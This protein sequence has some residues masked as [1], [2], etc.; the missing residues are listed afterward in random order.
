MDYL[1]TLI[2]SGGQNTDHPFRSVLGTAGD[3]P[4][5]ELVTK[6]EM[7][8]KQL[9][10]WNLEK[11]EM[12]LECFSYVLYMQRERERGYQARCAPFFWV[13]CTRAVFSARNPHRVRWHQKAQCTG[14]MQG[15][16]APR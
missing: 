8:S 7:L 1:C 12:Y 10:Y 13:G 3:Q 6:I 11:T 4:W 2:L 16:G 14:S 9:V 15:N 5:R